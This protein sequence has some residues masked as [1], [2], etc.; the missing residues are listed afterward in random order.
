MKRGRRDSL[1]Y[2][3]VYTF[4]FKKGAKLSDWIR[5]RVVTSRDARFRMWNIQHI[6]KISETQMIG[7]HVEP[8]LIKTLT[9]V[10]KLTHL[11]VR[12]RLRGLQHKIIEYLWRPE[13][14]LATKYAIRSFP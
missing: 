9:D 10:F 12:L 2:A 14:A 11:E 6:L 5:K 4:A 8:E 13:G 3:N 1:T 7:K